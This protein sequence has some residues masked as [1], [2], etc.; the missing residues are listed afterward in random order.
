MGSFSCIGS[1]AYSTR[2]QLILAKTVDT[3]T[4]P[5][6]IAWVSAPDPISTDSSVGS[7]VAVARDGAFAYEDSGDALDVLGMVVGRN[8]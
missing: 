5:G 8:G 3:Y 1:N 7:V 4:S 6:L 2:Y